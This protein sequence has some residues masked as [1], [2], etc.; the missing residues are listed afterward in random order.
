MDTAHVSNRPAIRGVRPPGIER[1]GRQW[2]YLAA[3]LLF[4]VINLAGFGPS[5]LDQS[6][7]RL[8]L[9]WLVAAHGTA[10]GAWFILFLAQATL[11]TID[12]AAVHRRMGLVGL[13]LAALIVMLGYQVTVGFGRRGFDLS[14]DVVR[15]IS[16]TGSRSSAATVVF[17]LAELVSF[18][19][20][21]VMALWYR[22][23]PDVHKRLMLFALIVIVDEP[24]L[25]FV[26]HL[27]SHW[28]ILR[29][30]GTRISGSI[31][32]VLLSAS[33]VHDRFS[34]GR[35]HRVSLVT[36]ILLITWQVVIVLFVFPSEVWHRCAAWLV[37]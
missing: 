32:L 17:P 28:P 12:R 27:S 29:G 11:I 10:T 14:G 3:G 35:I 31:L 8:P 21:V 15:A 26:G 4:I 7:R 16:R 30:S 25:H 36:P 23:R 2:F 22:R 24:L 34:F 19:S 13:L 20:L 37:R 6:A 33:A 5:I 18:A 1:R 9:T